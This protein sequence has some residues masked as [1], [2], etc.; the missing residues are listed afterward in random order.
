MRGRLKTGSWLDRKRLERWRRLPTGVVWKNLSQ[1]VALAGVL[2]P[3]NL[4]NQVNKDKAVCRFIEWLI[5]ESVRTIKDHFLLIIRLLRVSSLLSLLLL[6]SPNW[7]KTLWIFCTWAASSNS[8]KTSGTSRERAGAFQETDLDGPL[9]WR[10]QWWDEH[11]S[12]IDSWANS[13]AK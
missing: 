2:A 6:L 3:G 12:L 13:D 8:T 10:G 11:F 7:E 5:T 9:D 1:G 4:A